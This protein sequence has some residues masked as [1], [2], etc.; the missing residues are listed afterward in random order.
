M[1]YDYIII[2]AGLSGATLG[3][4]LKKQGY[5]VLIIEKSN[6]KTKEKLCGGILTT[7]AYN[8]LIDLF[9]KE[10][11]DSFLKNKFNN[12]KVISKYEVAINN[13]DIRIIDRKKLD[14]YIAQ[15]YTEI[16][17]EILQE[18][19]ADNIDFSNNLI[20][21]NDIRYEY[22]NLVA[23]D[24]ALSYTR[25]L[26][27]GKPQR[28][29]FAL[30]TFL[31]K[32]LEELIIE[33]SDDF[34]GYNWIIPGKEET[35]IGT[36]DISMNT[37]ISEEFERITKKYDIVTE[38]IKGAFL[39][40]GDDVLLV[41][42]NVFFIGDAAGLISPITG[43]GIYSALVSAYLLAKCINEHK[44][45]ENCMKK[46]CRKIKLELKLSKIIYNTKIRNRVFKILT[47]NSFIAR[48]IKKF[49]VKLILT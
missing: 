10:E 9:N 8:L 5:K 38:T 16:G 6:L 7:K 46:I 48:Q 14:Y 26:L 3:Y 15:K 37:E 34:I 49:V 22:K 40:T 45:Y 41:K 42:N 17:G 43:E 1:I 33:F 20:I 4:L 27:T 32:K 19:R 21:C 47:K 28:K 29:N 23:A 30:E 36:G 2:G 12:C 18:T 44:D 31:N 35:C 11:I 13:I 39:P 24:G 25:Q